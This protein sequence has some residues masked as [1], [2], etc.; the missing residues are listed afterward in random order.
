MFNQSRDIELVV[1]RA[2]W[3]RLEGSED[4]CKI[5]ALSTAENIRQY[6]AFK[7]HQLPA[8]RFVSLIRSSEQPL[9]VSFSFVVSLPAAC[10]KGHLKMVQAE[11]NANAQC[12]QVLLYTC[13]CINRIIGTKIYACIKGSNGVG[14]DRFDM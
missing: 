10:F 3:R 12:K 1:F 9:A 5:D 14:F 13:L 11:R 4:T 7:P 8:A 6:R 2:S